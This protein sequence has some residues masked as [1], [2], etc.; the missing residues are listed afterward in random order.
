MEELRKLWKKKEKYF[1]AFFLDL[2]Q[3][4]SSNCMKAVI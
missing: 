1:V 4:F 3:G 2:L